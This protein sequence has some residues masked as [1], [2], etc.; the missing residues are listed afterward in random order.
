MIDLPL[1][2]ILATCGVGALLAPSLCKGAGAKAAW[3]LAFVPAIALLVLASHTDSILSGHAVTETWPW[4]KSLGLELALRLDGLGLLFA[5]LISFIGV[6]VVIYAGSYLKGH[7]QLGRFYAAL[8]VFMGAMLGI[9]L[10]DNILAIFVFWELTSISSYLL[11]GFDHKRDKARRAATQALLTTAMG[12]L[13]LLAGMVLIGLATGSWRVSEINPTQ[14]IDHAWYP[15]IVALVVL[16]CATKS[17]QFPFHFWLPNAMEAPAPVSAYLHSSTMVKAGVFLL[18]RMTPILGAADASGQTP[19]LWSAT[20]TI[21]GAVTAVYAGL[22]ALRERALKPMLAYSTV[23]SLGMIVLGLGIGS[24][25]AIQ[26]ALAFLL[27]HAL[28]KGSLFMVAGALEYETGEKDTE[29]LRGLFPISPVLAIAAIVAALSM[30]GLI[31]TPGF[32]AKEVLLEGATHTARSMGMSGSAA[33]ILATAALALAAAFSGYVAIATGIRPFFGTRLPTPEEPQ[34]VAFG[35]YL[36]P[37]LLAIV[38]ITLVVKLEWASALVGSA[39]LAVLR[40]DPHTHLHFFHG[41]T[42]ELAVSLGAITLGAILYVARHHV[43]RALESLTGLDRVGPEAAYEGVLSGSLRFATIAT[44]TIQCGRVRV[45]LLWVL[46]TVV[47]CVAAAYAHFGVRVLPRIGPV[48]PVDVLIVVL[49]LAAAVAT[50]MAHRRLAA[51]ASLGIIGFG[52]SLLYVVYGAPDL[53]LTQVCVEALSTVLLLLVFR[54]V[55]DFRRISLPKARRRDLAIAGLS[56]IFVAAMVYLA[57]TADHDGTLRDAM[58]AKSLPEGY[59]RNVVNVILVDFR[60]LD[61]MGEIAVLGVAA[62]GVYT[63]LRP[64]LRD[65]ALHA[66]RRA[67]PGTSRAPVTNEVTP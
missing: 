42:T 17:A 41:V 49:V 56:G 47:I 11:I 65:P 13:A 39:S 29:K 1:I 59:G 33:P 63:L 2:T 24:D 48:H 66:R 62:L 21:M 26:G 10:S 25:L 45:Y 46:T 5:G 44:Q 19:A 3:I 23:S 52:L 55:P 16:G 58:A 18:A 40:H 57:A 37:L 7:P 50:A 32:V 9:A 8:L 12:G 22:R 60:G 36:G 34:R 4:A 14:I 30:I 27:A 53:A 51:I 43:R 54:R 20:L 61:T 38:A 35:L 67:A 64:A 6:L 28:Y 15:W 31:A